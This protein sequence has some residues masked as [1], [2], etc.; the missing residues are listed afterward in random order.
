MK[1]I[2]Y[3]TSK[4]RKMELEV[5]NDFADAFNKLENESFNEFQ[6]ATRRPKVSLDTLAEKGIEFADETDL[7]E[8][9][10]KILEIEKLNKAISTLLIDQQDL[11]R[12][13]FYDGLSQVE[14]AKIMGIGKTAI[15]NRL[16]RIYA[17]LKEI[18]T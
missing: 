2:I 5:S 9:V 17:K 4:T 3:K 11:I 16:T 10:C 13:I 8:E 12:K 1:T 14:V 18:L 7:F 6:K 15:A